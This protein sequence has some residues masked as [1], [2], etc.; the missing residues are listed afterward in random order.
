MKSAYELAMEKLE[1]EEPAQKLSEA[2]KKEIT[3]LTSLYES[4]I[5]ER[6]TFLGSLIVDAQ[7]KGEMGEVAQLEAQRQR[8]IAS[9]KE[10]LEQKK[11]KIW[12]VV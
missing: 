1:K 7:S 3:D 5:A 2:Q 4:K 8:D 12:E 9:L 6:E 11:K 10:E